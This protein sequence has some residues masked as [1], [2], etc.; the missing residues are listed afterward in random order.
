MKNSS[1]EA[2]S[3]NEPENRRP[4][5]FAQPQEIAGD[6]PVGPD[7]SLP[8]FSRHGESQRVR[9]LA[10][11]LRATKTDLQNSIDRLKK[12]NSDLKASN[13]QVVLINEELQ[14]SQEELQSLNEELS[15]INQQLQLKVAELESSH[16]DIRNL[17][18][19]SEI[20]TICVECD[21]CIKWFTPGAGAMFSMVN[22][23]IGRNIRIF[24]TDSLGA[25]LIEDA[26][27][28][29]RTLV[30]IQR[31]LS[32]FND[33]W[34]LRRILPY[35]T[36]DDQIAGVVITYTDIT[37]AKKAAEATAAAQYA[38]ASSLE[39]R[40]RERTTQLRMLTAELTLTEERERR[41]LAQDLHD[42]LGQLLAILKIKLTSIKESD[43]RGMLRGALKEIE[44]LIDQSNQSVR[45]LM[46]QL[47]PPVLQALGLVPAFEWLAEEMARVYG[48]TV[49]VDSKGAP[50]TLQEPAKTTIF[51]A[52]RELLINVSKHTGCKVAELS[53]L[54][55]AERLTI[56][57]I[58]QGDGFS[59]DPAAS[60]VP[61]DSGFG[62][63]SIKDRIEFVGGDMRI[64]TAPGC[65]TTVTIVFPLPPPEREI[66]GA[67]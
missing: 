10:E 55:D 33:T 16:A 17:L 29:L 50:M 60:V 66:K 8:E 46:Q 38:L 34:Y 39:A 25:A 4:M 23:D 27:C 1:R 18:A 51:R 49:H 62:L 20:A 22:A 40:V 7:A 42:G 3:R 54:R 56:S 36:E 2:R 65:G 48:L 43:R 11:A 6:V 59:Y 28:V 58:D 30:P 57:V 19:S 47:S 35:R 24:S 32:Y 63:T 45:T 31:E 12:S 52:V 41:V 21:Y 37:E 61:D 26:D 53:C 64:D 67:A 5:A 15:T 9:E 44:N 14:N 13:D